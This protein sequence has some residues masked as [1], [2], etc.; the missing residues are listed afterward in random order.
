ME[1]YFKHTTE[2]LINYGY[3]PTE[4]ELLLESKTAYGAIWTRDNLGTLIPIT[5]GWNGF[6]NYY[7][8][9]PGLNDFPDVLISTPVDTEVI[10][11]SNNN[12]ENN[13]YV[14]T[15]LYTNFYDIDT[16]VY[17][18]T[19]TVISSSTIPIEGTVLKTRETY[20]SVTY[21]TRA[22]SSTVAAN[23]WSVVTTASGI[24]LQWRFHAIDSSSQNIKTLLR[25]MLKFHEIVVLKIAGRR[26][27]VQVLNVSDLL[28][29][30]SAY[31]QIF[32]T[33][34]PH[35]S[36]LQYYSTLPYASISIEP[37]TP[38]LSSGISDLI[39]LPDGGN[40]SNTTIPT[41]GY[42]PDGGSLRDKYG[43]I[44]TS[45]TGYGSNPILA[46]Q[47]G[48]TSTTYLRI[49]FSASDYELFNINDFGGK[50]GAIPAPGMKITIYGNASAG[51]H[52][53]TSYSGATWIDQVSGL[54]KYWQIRTNQNL[55]TLFTGATRIQIHRPNGPFYEWVS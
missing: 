49:S 41:I 20:T 27:R 5:Q 4:G 39:Y 23:Q 52:Y 22:S 31:I 25:S 50:G 40:F 21:D 53:L 28:D 36:S 11:Y 48:W 42:G 10:S 18:V 2:P 29:S 55:A 32:T 3:L 9:V 44:Y 35:E 1:V 26:Y 43:Y 45:N 17:T 6:I 34:Y 33:L 7:Y 16:K 38:S 37:D 12:W 24:G 15:S 19:P 51:D 14:F 47:F 30:G 54:G 13:S 46:G 8:D